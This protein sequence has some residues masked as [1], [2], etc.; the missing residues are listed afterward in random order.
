[1]KICRANR[2]RRAKMFRV[3]HDRQS[4]IVGHIQPFVAIRGP[5]IGLGESAYSMRALGVNS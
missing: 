3:A 2:H 4:R 5:G 1:V